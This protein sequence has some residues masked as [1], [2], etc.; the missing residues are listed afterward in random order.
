M[1]KSDSLT[2]L[3]RHN[4]WANLRLLEACAELDDQQMQA[5]IPGSQ[6]TI[7]DTLEHITTA[8]LSYF[9]RI[10]TGQRWQRPE[11]WTPMTLEAMTESLRVTG[12]GLVEWAG[13]VQAG[14]T[15]MLDW[16][17]TP[18]QVP[19]STILTQVINHA[20][21]HREQVKATMTDLGIEPP[22]LSS[23]NYFDEHAD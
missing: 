14:D 1:D 23:W 10:S 5:S 17:G 22:D 20:T 18:R 15:V 11:D 6:G 3:F 8:E 7:R 19:K 4:Q 21:E 13:K 16:D 12:E 9:A 2:N